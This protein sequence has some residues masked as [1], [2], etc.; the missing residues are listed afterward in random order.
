M[1]NNNYRS[2]SLLSMFDKIFENFI[3]KSLDEKKHYSENINLIFDQMIHAQI[4]Y[5]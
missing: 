5:A 3:F 2:V 4:S 1:T